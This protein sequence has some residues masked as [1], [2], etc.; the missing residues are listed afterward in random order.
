LT[1]EPSEILLKFTVAAVLLVTV[2]ICHSVTVPK[3][4]LGGENAI[5]G[6]KLAV[7][8]SGAIILMLVEALFALATGPVQLKKT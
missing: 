5:T 3:L 4:T 1:S 7:T 6:M 2:R 8:L